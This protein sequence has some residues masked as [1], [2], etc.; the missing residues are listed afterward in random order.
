MLSSWPV[1]EM[2]SD[3][4]G[5]A[6]KLL[7]HCHYATYPGSVLLQLLLPKFT[8]WLIDLS[9]KVLK[10]LCVFIYEKWFERKHCTY[11]LFHLGLLSSCSSALKR[12]PGT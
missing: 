11:R 12:T 9:A 6:F 5:L 3:L 10:T 7:F 8:Y 4:P 2:Q 1:G